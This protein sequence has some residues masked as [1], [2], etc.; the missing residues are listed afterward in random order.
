MVVIGLVLRA[1]ND[2]ITMEKL[3]IIQDIIFLPKKF[4]DEGNVSIYSLIKESGYF[5]LHDQISEADIFKELSQHL[6]CID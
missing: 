1:A 5:E 4:Y 6:E 3:R 2:K